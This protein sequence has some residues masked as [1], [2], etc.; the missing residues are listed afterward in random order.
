MPGGSPGELAVT[1]S[2]FSITVDGVQ[3]ASFSELVGI[4]S[5]ALPDDF[6]GRVLKKLPGK[7]TPPTVTLARGM[8]SDLG[9][10]AWHHSVVEGQVAAARKNADLVMFSA[11]GDA[12][13]K[14]HMENSWPSK[15]VVEPSKSGSSGVLVETVTFTCDRLVRVAP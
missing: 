12:V 13:A 11:T 10:Y 8:T 2:R 3:V 14:Y 6:A 5:E 15:L 1:V 4:S 7:R 9:I